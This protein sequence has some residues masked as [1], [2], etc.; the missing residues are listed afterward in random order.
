M[1]TGTLPF[2]G[3]SSAVI[4]DAILNH[5]P[6]PPVRLNPDVSSELERIIAKALE[7]DKKLRCQS[8]AEMRT[9]LQRLKRDT[10]SG[11]TAVV[12]AEPHA[13]GSVATASAVGATSPASQTAVQTASVPSVTV[14]TRT[15]K[16][17]VIAG[18]AVVSFSLWQDGFILHDEQG[19]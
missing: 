15:L 17:A 8:A 3:E 6:V 18:A 5:A 16:W 4:T 19:H 9:D 2:R 14:P 10:E 7:K 11:R 13:T 12:S 1:A